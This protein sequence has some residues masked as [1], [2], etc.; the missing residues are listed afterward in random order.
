MVETDCSLFVW[1]HLQMHVIPYD[2]KEVAL[3]QNCSNV[4]RC[5]MMTCIVYVREF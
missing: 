3:F 2:Q 4:T 1:L 5:I